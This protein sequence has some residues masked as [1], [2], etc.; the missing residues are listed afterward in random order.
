MVGG[1]AAGLSAATKAR[2]EGPD[3]E[4][5]VLERLTGCPTALHTGMTV[6]EVA[7]LGYSPPFGAG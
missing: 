4:V 6:G 3:P 1:D 7:D 5:V 2:R